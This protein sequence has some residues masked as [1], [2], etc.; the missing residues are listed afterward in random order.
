MGYCSQVVLAVDRHAAPS[1]MA[2]L[3]KN[4][5]A[6][7]LCFNGS[8]EATPDYGEKGSLFIR[9]DQIKWYCDFD[10]VKPIQVFI[11]AM[12]TGD[13]SDY[14]EGEAPLVEF[15]MGQN[16]EKEMRPGDWNDHFRFVRLGEECGDVESKGYAFDI[17]IDRA[18]D[19]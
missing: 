4:T 6:Y 13:L 17:N 3:A 18:I 15:R 11:D 1:F 8:D 16:A 9:W 5:K 7:D 14:G 12:E 10:D 2:M 19:Y